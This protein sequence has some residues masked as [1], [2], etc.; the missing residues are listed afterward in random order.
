MLKGLY[1]LF[2]TIIWIFERGYL[3]TRQL[4]LIRLRIAVLKVIEAW[5][6]DISADETHSINNLQQSLLALDTNEVCVFLSA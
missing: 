5:F 2:F 3:T 1:A 4:F 6:D